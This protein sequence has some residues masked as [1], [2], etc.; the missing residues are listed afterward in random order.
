MITI[1]VV[2]DNTKSTTN[3]T[4]KFKKRKMKTT[5]AVVE[6][7]FLL[8]RNTIDRIDLVVLRVVVFVVVDLLRGR[9]SSTK[10]GIE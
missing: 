9:R 8:L 6:D 2:V 3:P 1:V 5:T 4:T 7:V 10:L